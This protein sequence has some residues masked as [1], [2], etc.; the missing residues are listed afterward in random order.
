ML[1]AQ[2]ADRLVLPASNLKILTVAVAAERLGWDFRF[3]TR[4]QAVGPITDGTLHGDLVVIGSGDPSI[5]SSDR[6]PAQLFSEWADALRKAGITRI[7]G[8]LVGDDSAFDDEGWGP[9]W[10][11]DYLSAGYAAPSGALNYNENVAL[12]RV[13]ASSAPSSAATVVLTPPGHLLDLINRVTTGPAGSATTLTVSRRPGSATLL[14]A[15]S[16]PAGSGELIRTA[17]VDNPTHTFVEAMRLALAEHG[18]VTSGGAW[19][20]D[21]LPSPIAGG[22][23]REIARHESEPLSSLAGYA[24][25]VSQNF[26]GETFLKAIG[27]DAGGVGSAESGRVVV[28][29][30]VTGW[31]VPSDA[32]VLSDGSGLSRY[33]YVTAEAL[34]A[35]LEHVWHDERLRGPFVASLP[36]G[37]HDGTLETRMKSTVLDR[38][39]QAKTGTISNV[40]ALSGYVETLSGEKLDFVIIVNNFTATNAAIDQI[41]E[42]ALARVVADR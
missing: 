2:N 42:Q 35:V 26:Y 22:E 18:I 20:E 34:G 3:P 7:D 4:L 27:H 24:M 17:A 33:D 13:T 12:V 6:G 14:V 23:R 21:D 36:V 37:A 10:S 29:R 16:V 30:V 19:D 41:A 11:W 32:L 28:R 9:G 8:R 25:K 38:R 1:Y 5:G 40:R 31:G 15:G 39:V